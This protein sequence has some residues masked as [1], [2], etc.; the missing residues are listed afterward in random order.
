MW[1]VCGI[2]YELWS[3]CCLSAEGTVKRHTLRITR[4]FVRDYFSFSLGPV[5]TCVYVCIRESTMHNGLKPRRRFSLRE[6]NSIRSFR[7]IC[8]GS[9]ELSRS[10]TPFAGCIGVAVLASTHANFMTDVCTRL[11]EGE[12]MCI[13]SVCIAVYRCYIVF[14]SCYSL[15]IRL[16]LI[17]GITHTH[18]HAHFYRMSCCSLRSLDST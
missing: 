5:A 1:F 13:A 2:S 11:F 18:T 16:D 4:S 3:S 17:L 10:I 15:C 8:D 7:I 6:C 14:A 9:I 12:C